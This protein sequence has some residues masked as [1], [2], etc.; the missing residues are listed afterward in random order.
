[1][2]LP[3]ASGPHDAES[4]DVLEVANT[5]GNDTEAEL[6]SGSSDR[7]ILEGDAYSLF[8]L[9]ALDPACE[10]GCLD[11]HPMHRHVADDY[12]KTDLDFP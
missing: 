7:E 12:G 6:Q 8:R 10:P 1:M 4:G 3:R 5:A 9:L 2:F 11:C